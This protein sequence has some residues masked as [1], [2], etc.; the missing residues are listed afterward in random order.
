MG[1]EIPFVTLIQLGKA[2]KLLG[3]LAHPQRLRHQGFIRKCQQM[4][5]LQ[6]HD[7]APLCGD[8]GGI[9]VLPLVEGKACALVAKG[10]EMPSPICAFENLPSAK[11]MSAC[12]CFVKSQ[13]WSEAK[14]AKGC[15]M[16]SC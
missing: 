12:R 6:G 1:E 10:S 4:G 3:T 14:E 9:Y 8:A 11:S 16:R 5:C 15:E 13:F 2:D 7:A